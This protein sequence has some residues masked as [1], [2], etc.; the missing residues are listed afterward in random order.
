VKHTTVPD[1]LI[2]VMTKKPVATPA[3]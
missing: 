1:Y 3:H 2:D